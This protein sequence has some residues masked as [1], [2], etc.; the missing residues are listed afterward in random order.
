MGTGGNCG[1]L[2]LNERCAVGACVYYSQERE[3]GRS[4]N[5]PVQ[6]VQYSTRCGSFPW[7]GR[8]SIFTRT[9]VVELCESEIGRKNDTLFFS[10]GDSLLVISKVF[11]L[12]FNNTLWAT[13]TSR[14]VT[15]K[16]YKRDTPKSQN[17]TLKLFSHSSTLLQ[18]PGSR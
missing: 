15:K 7:R 12:H 14:G 11:Y 1:K 18:I 13:Y 6:P 16:H 9:G 3:P 17:I 2:E 4:K 8:R 5:I 10:R